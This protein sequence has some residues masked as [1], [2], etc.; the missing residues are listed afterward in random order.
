M[1]YHI[2]VWMPTDVYNKLPR[3]KFQLSY[4]QHAI[5]NAQM[6]RTPMP[7]EINTLHARAIEVETN[8]AGNI[9]KVLYRAS[10]DTVND[11]V[12]AAIP[13]QNKMIVKTIW[14]NRKDDQHKTLDTTRYA[15]KPKG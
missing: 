15:K 4:T 1:L 13:Q 8:D 9:V 7:K 12:I 11:A 3:G 5:E 14:K 10:L 6:R 2:S